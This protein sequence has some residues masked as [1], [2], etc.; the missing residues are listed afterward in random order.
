MPSSYS[1]NLRLELQ[2][3]GENQGTWGTKLNATINQIE[4]AISGS[5]TVTTTG[6][7]TTLTTNDGATDQARRARVDVSGVLASN[8]EIVVPN[9]SKFYLIS[10]N[11]TGGYTVS[12]KTA[13]GEAVVIPRGDYVPFYIDGSDAIHIMDGASLGDVKMH[14][15]SAT[16]LPGWVRL[17]ATA[18]TIGNASSGATYTGERFRRLFDK[19]KPFTAL[20]NAGTEDFD[21]NDTVNLM[22]MGDRVPVGV[23]SAKS[24]GDTGGATTQTIAQANLP[25]INLGFSLVAASHAHASGSLVAAAHNHSY[26]RRSGTRSADSA[27][28]PSYNHGSSGAT[29]GNTAPGVTGVTSASGS[30]GVSGTISLGGSGTALS[31]EQPYFGIGMY[32][33]AY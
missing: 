23:G 17:G 5:V 14:F 22:A 27:G 32:A 31:I 10:N 2:A 8:A 26:D 19:M 21:S 24:L 29:T 16:E 13:S 28:G 30:L 20:S 4:A 3:T 18:V 9:L 11:T 7:T 25:A 1:T 33:K 15:G 12:V 6:G